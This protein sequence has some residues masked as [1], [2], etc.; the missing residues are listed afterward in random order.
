M[1]AENLTMAAPMTLATQYLELLPENPLKEPFRDAWEGM[2]QNYS[3][4]QIATWGSL[5]VHEVRFMYMHGT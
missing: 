2:L 1:A 5:L 4:L 3:K